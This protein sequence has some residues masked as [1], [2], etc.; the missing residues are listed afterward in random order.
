MVDRSTGHLASRIHPIL[1]KVAPLFSGHIKAEM[2]QSAVETVTGVCPNITAARLELR[3]LRAELARLMEEEGLALISAGTHPISRWQDQR[4]T[5]NDRYK[6]LEVEFQDVGRSI[7]I[8]GLHVHVAS[9]A[10]IRPF[11]DESA[12]NVVAPLTCTLQ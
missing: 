4:R 9:I 3:R 12:A 11:L 10:T 1:D 7:L 8:F 6:E 2:L 5:L